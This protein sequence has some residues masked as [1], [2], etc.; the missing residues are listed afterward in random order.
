MRGI[1]SLR[2]V[3]LLLLLYQ[4]ALWID[5]RVRLLIDEPGLVSFVMRAAADRLLEILELR[6]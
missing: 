3:R 6:R 4:L 1:S 2:T 5:K